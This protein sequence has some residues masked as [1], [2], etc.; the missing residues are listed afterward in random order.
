MPTTDGRV[1]MMDRTKEQRLET[2]LAGMLVAQQVVLDALIREGAIGYHQ[3]RETLLDA[4]SQLSARGNEDAALAI[5]PL[6]KVLHAIDTLHAPH[7]KESATPARDWKRS[8]R[9]AQALFETGG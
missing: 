9:D 1:A 5:E 7:S 6:R 2:L 8:L 3:L 4:E